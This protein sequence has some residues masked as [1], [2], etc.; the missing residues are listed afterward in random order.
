MIQAHGTYPFDGNRWRK[1][2]ALEPAEGMQLVGIDA[3]TA[4]MF[5]KHYPW[6]NKGYVILGAS[7]IKGN[8]L[9]LA[10]AE[11]MTDGEVGMAGI[12]KGAQAVYI[13]DG[14]FSLIERI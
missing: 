5:P 11:L 9:M 6:I 10:F 13:H 3:K 14:H 1:V 7:P 2:K 4:A 8:G 12:A